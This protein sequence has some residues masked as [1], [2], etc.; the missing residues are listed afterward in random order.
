[1]MRSWFDAPGSLSALL[2]RSRQQHREQFGAHRLLERPD[3]KEQYL[4]NIH[5]VA[6]RQKGKLRF[7]R[8]GAQL[9]Y[10]VA[11]EDQN[12]RVLQSVPIG[13]HD[14]KTL[15]VSCQTMYRPISLDARFSELDVQADRI[16]IPR[17]TANRE[18]TAAA[19]APEKED[20]QGWAAVKLLGVGIALFLAAVSGLW[21][22]AHRGRRPE[23]GG[24]PKSA[25]EQRG[26]REA[27]VPPVSFA[28]SACGKL[29]KARAN[30]AGRKVKCIHCG[31]ATLVQE[32]SP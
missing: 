4:D 14:V 16:E 18:P 23:Q 20:S 25:P 9:R 21:L 13:T 7:S 2:G 8:T 32:Q 15:R 10:L 1:M 26:S 12:F 19:P 3:G 31:Q 30:L 6:T 28:C 5:L 17:P 29:L 11:E 27:A 24:S 22:Y